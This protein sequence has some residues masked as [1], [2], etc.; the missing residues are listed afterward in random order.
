MPPG[1]VL[2]LTTL[3]VVVGI[4]GSLIPGVPGPLLVFVAAI[5]EWWFLPSFVSPWTLGLFAV[6]SALSVAADWLSAA[7]GARLFGGSRW[8]LLG[9][10]VGALFGLPF[11]VTG[12]IL[13]AVFGAALCEGVFAGKEAKHA[14]KA[15]LGAGLGLLAGTV[16]RL[17]IALAMAVWLLANY[18]VA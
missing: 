7:A 11:G 1:V 12:L 5:F 3:L 17:M 2:T 10:P 9:A 6:L 18:L 4:L 15:G 14:L 16:G 8:S 13:G